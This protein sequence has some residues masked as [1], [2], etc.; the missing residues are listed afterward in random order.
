MTFEDAFAAL[1]IIAILRGVKPDEVEAI[2]GALEA[3][4]I[5]IVEVPLNS[6]EP[7]TSIATLNRVFAGRLVCG[8]G[9]VRTVIEVDA[10]AAAG[11]RVVVSPHTA[12]DVIRSTQKRGLTPVP[13]F[14]TA[15][16]A[17]AAIDAGARHLKLFPASTYGPGHVAALKAV[18][19]TDTQIIAVGGIGP[20]DMAA[21]VSAGVA[22]FGLG[23]ELYKP[24]RSPQEVLERARAAVEAFRA[25]TR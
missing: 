24:G 18:L 11:G 6:P 16:E 2:A 7:M 3:A 13:G 20:E 4:G 9:T 25:A 22:G 10:V 8:A 15:T 1:P 21:W 19:P 5:R 23:S 12:P 17:F 14:S